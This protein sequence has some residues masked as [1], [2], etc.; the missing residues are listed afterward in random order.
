MMIILMVFV[1]MLSVLSNHVSAYVDPGTGTAIV[2]SM[3][4]ALV[5]VL[6]SFFAILV[7][8]FWHPIKKLLSKIKGKS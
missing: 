8:I 7:K 6:T 2:S 4:P 1:F 5:A 3:W